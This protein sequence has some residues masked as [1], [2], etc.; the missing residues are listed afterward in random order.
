[1]SFYSLLLL[2]YLFKTNNS[3]VGLIYADVAQTNNEPSIIP[4]P[5]WRDKTKYAELKHQDST[6]NEEEI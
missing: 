4:Q 2:Q 6:P 3:V 1:M 5:D